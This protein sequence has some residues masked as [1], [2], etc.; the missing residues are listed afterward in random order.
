M[1]SA[2]QIAQFHRDGFL[3]LRGVF[4]GREL[5]LL[6]AAAD[7]V[8]AEGVARRGEHHLYW[9]QPDG[10]TT[11]FRS[12]RMWDRDPIFGAAT[13]NP[14]LLAAIGQCYGHVFVPFNDSFVCKIPQGNVPVPWHQDPPYGGP[15]GK[16]ES[17]P[18]GNFDTDIYLDHSTIANGCVWGIPGHHLVGH[19]EYERF[20]Q[21]QLF[22]DCGAVPLEMAP[23]DV[24][25][26]S[27]S[28]PHGSIGN[29]TATMRRIF[30]V[31]YLPQATFDEDYGP[32]TWAKAKDPAR[33]EHVARV[34][35]MLATRAALGFDGLAGSRVVWTGQGFAFDGAPTTPP[36]HWRTLSAALPADVKAQM[37]TLATVHRPC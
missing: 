32:S 9:P 17:C 4:H 30:Y 20:T 29:R 11:Y 25:F 5:D 28:A 7:Q 16:R 26:H 34:A 35:G 18:L 2:D 37:R 22:R 19:V 1:L 10:S 31:H 24:L 21:E 8:V 6:R 15:Q 14:T 12:E 13:V 33:P 23:G 36:Y 3:A 27:I